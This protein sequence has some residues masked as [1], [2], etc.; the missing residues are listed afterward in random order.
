M[1]PHAAAAQLVLPLQIARLIIPNHSLFNGLI[2]WTEGI[3]PILSAKD[4]L[5]DALLDKEIFS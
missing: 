5:G 2:R 4:S 1:N 3:E